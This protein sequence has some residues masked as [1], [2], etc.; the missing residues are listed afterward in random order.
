[1]VLYEG[2]IYEKTI[3]DGVLSDKTKE[4]ARKYTEKVYNRGLERSAQ[5]N[6]GVKKPRGKYVLYLHADTMEC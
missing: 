3:A 2:T 4:I 1:M 5:R 6:F